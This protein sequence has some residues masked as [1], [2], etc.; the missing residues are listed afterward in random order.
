MN[1]KYHARQKHLYLSLNFFIQFYSIVLTRNLTQSINLLF[2]HIYVA[3]K[4]SNT[5]DGL[6][7][8]DDKRPPCKS[9]KV[10]ERRTWEKKGAL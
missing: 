8:D 10:Q 9:L 5:N 7:R 6:F 1:Y 2:I 3:T 4:S